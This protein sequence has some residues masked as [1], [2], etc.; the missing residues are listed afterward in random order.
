MEQLPTLPYQRT[1]LI[2]VTGQ[3]REVSTVIWLHQMYTQSYVAI[4]TAF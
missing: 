3:Q 2:S 4:R 1:P